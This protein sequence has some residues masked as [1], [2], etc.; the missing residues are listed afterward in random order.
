LTVGSLFLEIPL[1]QQG[2][3]FRQHGFMEAAGVIEYRYG[4]GMWMIQLWLLLSALEIY[5]LLFFKYVA[6]AA[7][8]G[9]TI[10]C[11][12]QILPIQ[13]ITAGL[14]FTFTPINLPYWVMYFT[15]FT[16]IK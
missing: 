8:T 4:A 6:D 1:E 2:L 3:I 7:S 14:K 15:S 12:L 10:A 11:R 5:L 9:A 16:V 13:C